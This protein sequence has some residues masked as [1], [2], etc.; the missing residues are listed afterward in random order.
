VRFACRTAQSLTVR[1][2]TQRH[3]SVR[4]RRKS[5][6]YNAGRSGKP[7]QRRK[8]LAARWGRCG[9]TEAALLAEHFVAHDLVQLVRTGTPWCCPRSA[10]PT[11]APPRSVS[12]AP[13][14]SRSTRVA[15][16]ASDVCA[17]CMP[18]L[19]SADPSGADGARRNSASPK[20]CCGVYA[21]AV[22]PAI[23]PV[24][25]PK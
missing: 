20:R 3:R 8:E 6:E 24:G 14:C 4:F 2:A 9:A 12:S 16:A 19:K 13:S 15:A 17:S 1:T 23:V 18:M 5:R 10:P 25:L 7:A 22:K 11:T 21:G